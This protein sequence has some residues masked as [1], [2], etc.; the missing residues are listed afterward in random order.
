MHL[1]YYLILYYF[2]IGL[3]IFNWDIFIVIFDFYYL[4][5]FL[6]KICYSCFIFNLFVQIH[7][8]FINIYFICFI[9]ISSNLNSIIKGYSVNITHR[10]LHRDIK[11]TNIFIKINS[12]SLFNF[13]C[14]IE[15]YWHEVSLFIIHLHLKSMLMVFDLSYL[16]LFLLIP[17]VNLDVF[18]KI[19]SPNQHFLQILID[20]HLI[21]MLF[22]QCLFFLF[23]YF[24]LFF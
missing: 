7:Q 23:F 21:L 2:L 10:I 12:F 9:I 19:C 4:Y 14:N 1:N 22:W 17:I 5:C 18:L 24:Q 15:Y 8:N 3:A 20:F 13:Y 16:L 6:I 11:I